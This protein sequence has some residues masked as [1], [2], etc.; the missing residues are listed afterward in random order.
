MHAAMRG[1]P[2][3]LYVVPASV[4]SMGEGR[5]AS[6]QGVGTVLKASP[7]CAF[8]MVEGGAAATQDANQGQWAVLATVLSMEG[9]G[10]ASFQGV[11][12]VL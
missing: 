3:M 7:S 2:S 12:A 6:F 10:G 8:P 9:V 1:A 5:G 4:L 11:G